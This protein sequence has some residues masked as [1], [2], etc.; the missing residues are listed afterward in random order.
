MLGHRASKSG[1]RGWCGSAIGGI[2][3]WDLA[4]YGHLTHPDI[5]E[6]PCMTVGEYEVDVGVLEYEGNVR[7]ERYDGKR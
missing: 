7:I 3:I 1:R 5:E 4:L 6:L 2:C